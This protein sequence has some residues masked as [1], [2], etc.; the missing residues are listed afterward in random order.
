MSIL[1]SAGILKGL[2]LASP[3]SLAILG[4]LG[5]ESVDDLSADKRSDT[6]RPTR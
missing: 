4:A 2:V 6:F 1:G 3:P 5:E